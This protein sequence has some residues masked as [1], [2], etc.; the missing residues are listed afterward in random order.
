MC[1]VSLSGIARVAIAKKG[2]GSMTNFANTVLGKIPA[3]QLGITLVHETLLSVI[4][5]AQ[6]AYDITFDRSE[7]FA[8]LL[9][10]LKEFKAAG[11]ST[12]VDSSGMFHGRDLPLYESLSKATGV[13]IIASTGLGPEENL[14]GYFLTPQTNPPTPWP[15]EKFEELFGKEITEG[16]VRPRIERRAPAGLVSVKADRAQTSATEISLIKGG[17]SAARDHG[18]SLTLYFGSDVENELREVL[19]EGIQASRIVVSGVDR[20]DAAGKALAVAELGAVVAIDNVGGNSSE[21]LTDSQRVELV[22]ELIQA[23]HIERV[24]LS[25]NSAG[26]A[27]GHEDSPVGFA[28][29][30]THFVPALKAKGVTES[31][32]EQILVANPRNLLT[33]GVK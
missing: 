4:P 2:H 7:I 11:G 26:V 13:N 29:L 24:V 9:S 1:K 20:A 17:A 31:Q 3:D 14:G 5:G 16:M 10:K 28:F 6:Y 23:G 33:V 21:Y 25:T 30:L 19:S 32:L 15:A 12:L 8:N 18:P 22:W 27:K